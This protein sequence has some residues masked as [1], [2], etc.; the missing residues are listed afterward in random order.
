MQDLYIYIYIYIYI[1]FTIIIIIIIII[2]STTDCNIPKPGQP[3]RLE[4]SVFK[5]MSAILGPWL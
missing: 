2:N 1:Y 4:G 3:P 5:S